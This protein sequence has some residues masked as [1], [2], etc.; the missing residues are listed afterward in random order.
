MGCAMHKNMMTSWR[1][2]QEI[3]LYCA[4]G[5]QT[6]QPGCA[7]ATSRRQ[8]KVQEDPSPK[9]RQ[10]RGCK[11]RRCCPNRSACKWDGTTSPC[12]ERAHRN[13]NA[14]SG[15]EECH[16]TSLSVPL[17]SG[18]DDEVVW[19]SSVLE[20]ALPLRC[21]LS[22]GGN[23]QAYHRCPR[24]CPNSV[25]EPKCVCRYDYVC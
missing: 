12:V 10:T 3:Y 7:C 5:S 6:R 23:S 19:N 15:T 16:T 2:L 22:R 14:A 11:A 8:S 13:C 17:S 20:E 21:E 1:D 24:R 9:S 4:S 25:L 18:T